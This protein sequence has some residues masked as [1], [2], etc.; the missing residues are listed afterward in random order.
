MVLPHTDR[1][2]AIIDKLSLVRTWV[3]RNQRHL[4]DIQHSDFQRKI[5][6]N[7]EKGLMVNTE[8]YCSSLSASPLRIVIRFASQHPRTR[9]SCPFAARAR[10][11]MRSTATPLGAACHSFAS[12]LVSVSCRRWI[13]WRDKGLG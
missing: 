5:C 9:V 6:E 13:V 12:F 1:V 2:K 10:G 7:E 11:R 4:T 8:S 3:K